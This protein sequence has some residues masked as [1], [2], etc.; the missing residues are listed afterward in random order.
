VWTFESWAWCRGLS[1]SAIIIYDNMSNSKYNWETKLPKM[2]ELYTTGISIPEIYKQI[3]DDD[4]GFTPG[5]DQA[6]REKH[7]ITDIY[8]A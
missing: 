3:Q 2:I 5:Y 1:K 6:P 4:Q 7:T 8:K